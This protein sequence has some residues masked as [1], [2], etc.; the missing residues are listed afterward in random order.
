MDALGIVLSG[1]VAWLV[2]GPRSFGD[3]VGQVVVAFRAALNREQ[4]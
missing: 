3:H 1:V 4:S 2:W